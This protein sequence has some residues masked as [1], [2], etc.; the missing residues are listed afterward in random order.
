MI[1]E[2]AVNEIAVNDF[3]IDDVPLPANQFELAYTITVRILESHTISYTIRVT[4]TTQVTKTIKYVIPVFFKTSVV[5]D[6]EVPEMPIYG[7]Y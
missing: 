1:N 6:D 3:I 5:V 2:C 7:E 4:A